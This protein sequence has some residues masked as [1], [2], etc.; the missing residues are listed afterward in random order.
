MTF[1]DLL[2]VAGGPTQKA[3]ISK[4]RIIKERSN[5]ADGNVLYFDLE[6]FMDEGGN[7][8][9]LPNLLA[10]DSII[11][12]ELP[13]DPT[14]N[15]STWLRQSAQDSIYIFGAI[16]APGR[17]AFNQQMGF[18]DILLLPMGRPMT[19]I[20]KMSESATEMVIT[21]PLLNLTSPN[22]LKPVMRPLFLKL[23]RGC[24]LYPS[25]RQIMAR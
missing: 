8:N 7:F 13:H 23:F 11:I 4:I 21:V 16:G 6:R 25:T 3:N 15:K 12:D 1:L 22:I 5:R 17:Y 19:P 20:C 9:E 18:L 14:D 24:Y 2:A 10:G